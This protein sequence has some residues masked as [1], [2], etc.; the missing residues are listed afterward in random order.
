MIDKI[1]SNRRDRRNRWEWWDR[2]DR[3]YRWDR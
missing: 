2:G 1:N 3:L